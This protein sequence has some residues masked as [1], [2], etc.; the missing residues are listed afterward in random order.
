MLVRLVG[1]AIDVNAEQ[2]RK[3]FAPPRWGSRSRRPAAQTELRTALAGE[4]AGAQAS[5][6]QAAQIDVGDGGEGDVRVRCFEGEVVAWSR[7][8]AARSATL[9]N[10]G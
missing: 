9:A 1:S 8:A 4:V 2:S 3:A 6:E 5:R 10:C 7:S